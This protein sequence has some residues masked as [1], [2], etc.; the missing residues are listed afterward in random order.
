MNRQF[1]TTNKKDL[2]MALKTEEKY[3]GSFIVRDMQIKATPR[4]PF[5]PS[6]IVKIVYVSIFC[7][8]RCVETG[9]VYIVDGSANWSGM[10]RG[11]SEYLVQ[12]LKAEICFFSSDIWEK[13]DLQC[14]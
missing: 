1:T 2:E 4:C 10:T 13:A 8:R 14:S 11:F 12:K 9:T 3:S 5:P 6:R 7:W